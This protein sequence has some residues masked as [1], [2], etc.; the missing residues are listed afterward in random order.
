MRIEVV[1]EWLTD[2]GSSISSLSSE[3]SG[4]RG[5][6]GSQIAATASAAGFPEAME[7][8]EDFWRSWSRALEEMEMALT[9]LGAAVARAGTAYRETDEHAMPSVGG[10]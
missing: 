9:A 2:A 3:L 7:G 8:V 6:L 10:R 5:Q 4:A 1:T